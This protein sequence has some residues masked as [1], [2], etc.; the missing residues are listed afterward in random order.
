L[1]D[2]IDVYY[3]LRAFY[4][5]YKTEYS[6]STSKRPSYT[7]APTVGAEVFLYDMFSISGEYRLQFAKNNYDSSSNIKTISNQT[8]LILRLYLD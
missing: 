2:K 8:K 7:L 3:G 4:A 1:R 5:N 6:T